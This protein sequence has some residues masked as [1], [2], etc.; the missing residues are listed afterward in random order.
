MYSDLKK[1]FIVCQPNVYTF[2]FSI[3][4]KLQNPPAE[5]KRITLPNPGPLN[6]NKNTDVTVRLQALDAHAQFLGVNFYNCIPS[7]PL[8]LN[9]DKKTFSEGLHEI[10]MYYVNKHHPSDVTAL[11]SMCILSDSLLGLLLSPCVIVVG[12]SSSWAL[13]LS[14]LIADVSYAENECLSEIAFVFLCW[15]HKMK[16]KL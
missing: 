6:S 16:N 10:L 11:F 7:K 13:H 3:K 1:I 12:C 15:E 4:L 2:A 8:S 9:W 14:L 5:V